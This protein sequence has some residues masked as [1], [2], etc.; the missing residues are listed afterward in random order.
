MTNLLKLASVGALM[1]G[2]LV[3]RWRIW[4]ICLSK[5]SLFICEDILGLKVSEA[6]NKG[7]GSLM[8]GLAKALV[9][10][11]KSLKIQCNLAGGKEMATPNA[12]WK[13]IKKIFFA[14]NQ[15]F[16]CLFFKKFVKL[17]IT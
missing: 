4:A 6:A 9:T 13:K 1:I 11:R 14:W 12:G 17:Q 7:W 5:G 8:A 3:F 15:N 10:W 2:L 16:Y